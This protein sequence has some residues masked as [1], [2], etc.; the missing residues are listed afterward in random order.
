MTMKQIWV[1]GIAFDHGWTHVDDKQ[2]PAH[3]STGLLEMFVWVFT[4]CHT[5][6]TSDSSM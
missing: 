2:R 3:Q 6:Y 1:W 5:Q 4:T